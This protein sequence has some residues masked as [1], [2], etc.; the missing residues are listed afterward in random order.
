VFAVEMQPQLCTM[1]DLSIRTS[2][3][4]DW[5]DL[6]CVALWDTPDVDLAYSPRV[7]NL[8]ATPVSGAGAGD[9][10]GSPS[11][12]QTGERTYLLTY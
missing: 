8:G 11:G 7:G 1:L 6:R 10:S 2:G 9:G 12:V 3:Y 4:G 5:V